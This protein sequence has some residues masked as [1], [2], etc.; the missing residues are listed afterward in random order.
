MDVGI[1]AMAAA[2]TRTVAAELRRVL[3]G[4]TAL[5]TMSLAT[6]SPAATATMAAQAAAQAAAPLRH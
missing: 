5:V 3:A 2:A 1:A 4:C 6:P